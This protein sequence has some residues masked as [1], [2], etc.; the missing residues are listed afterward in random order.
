M[1]DIDEA[2][3]LKGVGIAVAVDRMLTGPRRPASPDVRPARIALAI[4]HAGRCWK[5][6]S[7]CGIR[8]LGQSSGAS[9]IL[10]ALDRGFRLDVRR[11]YGPLAVEDAG[12]AFIPL[13]LASSTTASASDRSESLVSRWTSQGRAIDLAPWAK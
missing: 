1:P 9:V 12:N 13:R 3:A 6:R 8:G 10:A 2:I 4:R 5:M 11:E 7:G